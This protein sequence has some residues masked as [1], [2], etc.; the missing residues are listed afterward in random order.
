MSDE[1]RPTGI[2]S[3]AMW[4]ICVCGHGRMHHSQESGCGYGMTCP[5]A[6]FEAREEE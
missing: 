4:A 2:G 6:K 1:E 3:P 5:C